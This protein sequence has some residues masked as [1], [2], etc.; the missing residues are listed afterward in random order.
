MVTDG[1]PLSPFA[2]R[3]ARPNAPTR[4]ERALYRAL[5]ACR[6]PYRA[7]VPLGPYI[8]DAYL[9]ALRCVIEVD[10][11]Y[12][13]TRPRQVLR[14]RRKDRYY[15]ARGLRVLRVWARHLLADPVAWV[16][17]ALQPPREP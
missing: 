16:Q 5:E 1:A 12:H 14:D 6:I 7:Q 8:A 3:L 10:G 13:H 2:A 11:E 4:P 15:R 17:R 9:P